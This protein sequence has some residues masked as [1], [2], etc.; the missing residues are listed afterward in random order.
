MDHRRIFLAA[1]ASFVGLLERVPG[2][3]R[4]GP[5]LGVWNDFN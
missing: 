2:D 4:D 5:G 3:R 1:A